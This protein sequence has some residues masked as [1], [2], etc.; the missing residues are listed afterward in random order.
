[1]WQKK[2]V[3][4][5]IVTILTAILTAARPLITSADVNAQRRYTETIEQVWQVK[6][7]FKDVLMTCH[8]FHL[9]WQENSHL[10]RTAR[11]R[12]NDINFY[13]NLQAY[14][15]LNWT[16]HRDLSWRNSRSFSPH[17]KHHLTHHITTQVRRPLTRSFTTPEG[18]SPLEL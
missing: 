15:L 6:K 14:N 16:A 8:S 11:S 2:T 1:M 4:I 3:R 12:Q 10:S 7:T 5:A 18:H 13:H 9:P 17:P